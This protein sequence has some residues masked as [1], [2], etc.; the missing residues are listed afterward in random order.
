MI[1]TAAILSVTA[2]DMTVMVLGEKWRASWFLLGII[3]LRSVFDVAYI[4]CIAIYLAIVVGL[5]RLTEPLK[6]RAN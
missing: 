3:V 4:L 6:L 2:Q 1:P 5:L